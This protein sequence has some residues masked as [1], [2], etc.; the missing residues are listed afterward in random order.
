MK[1]VYFQGAVQA[2]LAVADEPVPVV[3]DVMQEPRLVNML[4]RLPPMDETPATMATAIRPAINPYS[5][6]VTPV[7]SLRKR[8]MSA[9]ILFLV[10]VCTFFGLLY[11]VHPRISGRCPA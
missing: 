3:G 7:S 6:A 9:F 4:P 5:I 2:T 11:V 8:L 10:P 1:R